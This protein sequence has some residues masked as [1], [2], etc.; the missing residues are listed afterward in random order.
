[1]KKTFILLTLIVGMT[2]SLKAQVE[3]TPSA[4]YFWGGKV[5]FYEGVLYMSDAATYGI[6]VSAPVAP[7]KFI[8][9]NY[10][11]TANSAEFR[12]YVGF[13]Y[14]DGF[15]EAL[16][17]HYWMLGS[18]QQIKTG[19]K[20]EPYIGLNLGASIFNLDYQNASNLWRFSL[21]VAGGVKIYMSDKVGLR[22]QGRLLM[23]MYFSGFGFYG[24]SGG[25]GMSMYA[26]VIAFQ[27]DVSAGLIFR[28]E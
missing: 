23:P 15:D 14:V 18:Y 6:A 2:F 1:M 5:N 7:G 8:E 10:S 24:G 20:A 11:Y 17:T 28:I 16:K 19:G 22:L 25:S 21:G 13:D 12:P 3:L 26:G 9:M 27:G 4:G